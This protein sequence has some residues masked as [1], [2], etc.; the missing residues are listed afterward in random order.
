MSKPV[1]SFNYFKP[2]D[3]ISPGK[4]NGKSSTIEENM[5]KPIMTTVLTNISVRACFEP[6]HIHNPIKPSHVNKSKMPF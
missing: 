2:K 5:T 4:Q 3:F 1:Q 6:T